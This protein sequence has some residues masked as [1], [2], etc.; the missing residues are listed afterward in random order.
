MLGHLYTKLGGPALKI[1]HRTKAGQ[2]IIVVYCNI[3]GF[4][5]VGQ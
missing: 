3:P 1:A 5:T 2:K 4:F